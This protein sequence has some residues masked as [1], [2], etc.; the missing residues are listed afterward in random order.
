VGI[1]ATPSGKGYWLVG[2]DGG[3][4]SFG[5]AAFYGSAGWMQLNKPIV[6]IA[7]TPSGK[8]YW[9][10]A[11]DGGVF[12]FGDAGFYGS[13]GSLLLNRPIIGIA[14][15]PNGHGYWL[16]ASDGGI[17][18]FGDASFY[19][20]TGS[21]H[22]N[23]PIIGIASTGDSRGYWLGASD[24]GIFSFGDAPFKGS[25]VGGLNGAQAV[26]IVRAPSNGYWVLTSSGA[27]LSHD[28]PAMPALHLS[29]PPSQGT[30]P[31]SPSP[32]SASATPLPPGVEPSASVQPSADFVQACYTDNTP[33]ECNTEALVDID[34]A[35]AGEG[36][37][38]LVLPA[39]YDNLS[40]DAQVLAVANAERTSRGLSAMAENSYLDSMAQNGVASGTDPDGPNG[41]G[42][43]SNIAWGYGTALAADFGWMYDDG[44]GGANIDCTATVTSGCWG[45]RKNILAPW[46]GEAGAG[47]MVSNGLV[48]Y[49]ELFVENF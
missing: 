33:A 15:T 4:F 5:D 29:V 8:G 47:Y 44:P 37:G 24:G 14:S 2:S 41:Y 18:S 27:V 48:S 7:A 22:L 17:F 16:A 3:V 13:T 9:L 25:S 10:V 42:W 35:R 11:S 30:P 21:L 36:L 43:G 38:R 12:S 19:G 49:S 34:H 46:G 1:A 45:H 31:P 6:G 26:G 28:A 20:S 39:D 40:Q 23:E 32:P